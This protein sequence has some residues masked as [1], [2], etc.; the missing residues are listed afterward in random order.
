MR[1]LILED[2]VH[3]AELI[4]YEVRKID[5][6]F[7]FKRVETKNDFFRELDDFKPD[8]ILSDYKLPSFRG[9]DALDMIREKDTIIPFILVSGTIGEEL[10]IESLKKGAT[11]YVLKNRLSALEPAIRRVIC[12]LEERKRRMQAQKE[13]EE[14]MKFLQNLIDLI[15]S[16]VFYKDAQLRFLGCNKAFEDYIGLTSEKM[17]GKTIYD[18]T[19]GEI[20]GVFHAMD[21]ELMGNPGV[22]VFERGM[23]YTDGSFRDVV[24]NKTTYND[25]T[26]AVAGLIGVMIDITKLKEAERSAREKEEQ[27]RMIVESTHEGIWVIDTDNKTT[28]LN[29]K[30]AEILGYTVDEIMGKCLFDFMLDDE[31]RSV[32]DYVKNREAG[33][34]E[35]H[36]FKFRR[37]NGSSLYA[38]LMTNPLFDKEGKYTGALAMVNDITDLKQAEEELLRSEEKYRMMVE[39]LNDMIFSMDANGVITYISPAV[40]NIAGYLPGDVTGTHFSRFVFPDDLEGITAS[41]PDILKGVYRPYEFRIIGRRKNLIYIRSS[42]RMIL[43]NG[44]FAGINGVLTDIT[45]Q[46]VVESL[47][48]SNMEK[49]KVLFNSGND[50][51]FVYS[52]TDDDQPGNFIEVNDQTCR[53]LGYTR[54]EFLALIPAKIIASDSQDMN[55]DNLGKLLVNKAVLYETKLVNKT[56]ETVNVEVNAHLFNFK[57]QRLVL[58]IARD[59]TG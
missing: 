56:G 55:M 53:M 15:P 20:A 29:E 5:I 41:F 16:P 9:L 25:E 40:K 34:V 54:P 35:Q 18:I 46:K 52:L 57:N 13:K 45:E 6:P 4:M 58:A 37:K 47:L 30:M 50:A 42:S 23:R 39:N 59:I 38:L 1:I 44:V 26:G 12:E 33:I 17:T 51:V 48:K 43:E 22:Q 32:A 49:Y 3:D 36:E 8:I 27:Y 19:S 24:F 10:A 21:M 2:N 28:Y 14:K 31:V 7:E 11:D